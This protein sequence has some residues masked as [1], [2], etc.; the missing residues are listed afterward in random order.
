MPGQGFLGPNRDGFVQ[1]LVQG[2]L[3]VGPE[4]L[5][6]KGLRQARAGLLNR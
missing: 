6:G 5:P 1:A 2:V 3:V 4:A